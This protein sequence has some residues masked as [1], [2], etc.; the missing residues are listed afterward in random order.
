MTG[1]EALEY[2]NGTH[3]SKWKLGLE[4]TKELLKRV[5]DPQRSLKFIHVVGTNGK[6]STCAMLDAMFREA[7]YTTG[8]YTSPFIFRFHER[9]QMNGGE[10]ADDELAVRPIEEFAQAFAEADGWCR[11]V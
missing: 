4:R 11:N 5:G 10:I 8:L 7:G 9:M 3:Y 2:L 6:G 1:K